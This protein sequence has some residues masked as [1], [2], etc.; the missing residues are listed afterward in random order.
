MLRPIP[1]V[2]SVSR[3]ILA[4]LFPLVPRE[5]QVWVV[6]IAAATDV[7][8]GRLARAVGASN[9]IGKYLDPAGDKVFAASVVI[10]LL[11]QGLLLPTDLI[12]LG[13][14]D[15]VVL[16]GGAVL[17]AAGRRAALADLSVTLL[18][19]AT[20]VAQLVYLLIVVGRQ[21]RFPEALSVAVAVGAL[22]ALDYPRRWWSALV[23]RPK[24]TD[25]GAG[26]EPRF[27]TQRTFRCSRT[28]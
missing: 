3:L 26:R 10:T 17:I 8:D 9:G 16:V 1:N 18:D 6:G 13:L 28:V 14:R 2:L 11:V 27:T 15:G 5:W 7:L 22:A 25:S 12:L 23:C 20:T 19:K 24:F 21:D 4:V